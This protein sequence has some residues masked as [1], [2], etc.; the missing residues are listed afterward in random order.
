MLS[1]LPAHPLQTSSELSRLNRHPQGE[2]REDG[3][4]AHL[5]EVG[6]NELWLGLAVLKELPN[7]FH[8][9]QELLGLQQPGQLP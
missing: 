7:A 2:I 6:S 9:S 8:P 5:D 3:V 4:G 1:R